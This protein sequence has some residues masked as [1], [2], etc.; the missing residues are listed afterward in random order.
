MSLAACLQL[1]YSHLPS[2][3]LRRHACYWVAGWLVFMRLVPKQAD[4]RRAEAA[5]SPTNA[6]SLVI[7]AL[8]LFFGLQGLGAVVGDLRPIW[9]ALGYLSFHHY[10]LMAVLAPNAYLY[11]TGRKWLR[12]TK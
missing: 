8:F 10:A 12:Q 1:Y 2:M 6:S 9:A 3:A 5:K 7:A 4:E 11:F